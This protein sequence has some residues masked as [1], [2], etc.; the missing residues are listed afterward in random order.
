VTGLN[1]WTDAAIFQIAGIPTVLFGPE[2]SGYH[3]AGEWVS[4]PDLV[5]TAE[6][7]RRAAV[8]LLGA[9]VSASR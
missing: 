5:A 3:A 7:L 2:G 8:S 4:I 6:I 9:P 1:A